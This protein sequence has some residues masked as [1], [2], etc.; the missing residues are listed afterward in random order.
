MTGG[1]L[2]AGQAGPFVRPLGVGLVLAGLAH[3]LAPGVLLWTARVAYDRVLDVRFEPRDSAPN[4]VRLVGAAM[5][6]TGAHLA[7]Y[8]AVIPA[9]R[10]G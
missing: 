10:D 9:E 1:S 6:A 7:Y 3:L 5:V 4:R 8:G 2:A